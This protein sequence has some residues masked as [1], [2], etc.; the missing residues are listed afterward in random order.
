M[1]SLETPDTLTTSSN[2]L[3]QR[4]GSHESLRLSCWSRRIRVGFKG[5]NNVVVFLHE[6]DADAG[7]FVLILEGKEGPQDWCLP[8]VE[9]ARWE[10]SL[11]IRPSRCHIPSG[12]RCFVDRV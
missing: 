4:A 9:T 12:T 6:P 10:N 11:A 3:A 7:L 1:R 2:S 8:L 5:Y